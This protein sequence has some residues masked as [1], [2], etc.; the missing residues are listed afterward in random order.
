MNGAGSTP[1]PEGMAMT[2]HLP[3]D[4]ARRL[5]AEA[6]RRGRDVDEVAAEVLAAGLP[7]DTGPPRRLSF[8]GIGAS[9]GKERVAERHREIIAGHFA[10][11]TASD[12]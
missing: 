6:Q 3:D 7:P 8:L 5:A 10:D 4:V 9:G 12:V 11:K 2:V 1:Y